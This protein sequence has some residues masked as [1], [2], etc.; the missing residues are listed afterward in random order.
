[1]KNISEHYSHSSVSSVATE[2]I[3]NIDDDKVAIY[4]RSNIINSLKNTFNLN[5]S[6]MEIFIA[7]LIDK[8]TREH[9]SQSSSN[10]FTYEETKEIEDNLEGLGYI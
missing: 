3:E 7:A 5:E 1:M 2:K 10:V 9:I 6:E 4:V 8:V